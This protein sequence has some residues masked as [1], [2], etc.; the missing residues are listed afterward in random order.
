MIDLEC[1]GFEALYQLLGRRSG[2]ALPIEHIDS[3]YA[4]IKHLLQRT[5]QPDAA[6]TAVQLAM[7]VIKLA[8]R[9]LEGW[10]LLSEAR[11]VNGQFKEVF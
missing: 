5:D 8:P 9:R 1:D 4:Q 7:T 2:Y 10:M 6:Q 11:I 3:I